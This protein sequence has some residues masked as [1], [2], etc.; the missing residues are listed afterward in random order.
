MSKNCVPLTI[1]P[2]R[3]AYG[4]ATDLL[5]EFHVIV[6][7]AV[8]PKSSHLIA[9]AL[10]LDER[11]G[12][13]VSIHPPIPH[14]YLGELSFLLSLRLVVLVVVVAVAVDG[15]L[16]RS[17]SARYALRALFAFNSEA[18]ALRTKSLD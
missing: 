9:T 17:I 15:L 6:H 4:F 8:V 2:L 3:G 14:M 5:P 10:S 7:P 1:W 11:G 13:H 16:S 12:S 18:S